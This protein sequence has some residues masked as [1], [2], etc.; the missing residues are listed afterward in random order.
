[1]RISDLAIVLML[2]APVAACGNA[3]ETPGEM[4]TKAGAEDRSVPCRVGQAADFAK[5]C[6][7]EWRGGGKGE[8]ESRSL[9]ILR[10]SDGGFRRVFVSA[11]GEIGQAD[12]SEPIRLVAQKDGWTEVAIGGDHYRLRA[13]QLRAPAL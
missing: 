9:L 2:V 4:M 6:T 5:V 10:H 7:L 1:M 11:G 3:G 13:L 8:N 12:G